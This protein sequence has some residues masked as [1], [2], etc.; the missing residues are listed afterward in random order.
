MS[1]CSFWGFLFVSSPKVLVRSIV[2]EPPSRKRTF[3]AYRSLPSTGNK[4]ENISLIML[5]P[6]A[7]VL[8]FLPLT[9]LIKN[10]FCISEDDSFLNSLQSGFLH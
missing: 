6:Q 9:K 2:I 1:K 3:S 7:P 4:K 5:P 10:K 8:S